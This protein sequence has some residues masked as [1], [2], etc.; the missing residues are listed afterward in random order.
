MPVPQ[1]RGGAGGCPV[2][3]LLVRGPGGDRRV[4]CRRSMRVENRRSPIRAMRGYGE[5]QAQ[6][7]GDDDVATDFHDPT[8]VLGA[9]RYSRDTLE[10]I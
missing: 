3:S 1:V 2:V 6:K 9:S 7:A 8:T 10:G 4:S 5:K